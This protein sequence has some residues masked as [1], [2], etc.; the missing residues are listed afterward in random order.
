M[1]FMITL[2][3]KDNLGLIHMLNITLA[4]IVECAT[5]KNNRNFKF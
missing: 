1:H 3:L 4:E 5:P 2:V